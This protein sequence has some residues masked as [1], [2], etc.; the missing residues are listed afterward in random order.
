METLERS[1]IETQSETQE[2][3]PGLPEPQKEHAWL[4]QLV[5]EWTYEHECQMGPGQPTMKATGTESVRSVGGLWVVG[6]GTGA[7]PGGSPA[8]MLIT[9]GFDAQKGRFVGTFIGS[10]MTNL[11]IYDGGLDADERVLTLEAD[12][13][14]FTDPGT[15]AKYR[16]VVEIVS[17]DHRLLKSSVLGDDGEWHEF[18]TAHYRRA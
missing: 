17:P 5:G 13:P 9:L 14:N 16:D 12:G 3:C 18:M 6:E 7:T 10:M 2:G 1:T 11:W 4:Q 8:T 15:T